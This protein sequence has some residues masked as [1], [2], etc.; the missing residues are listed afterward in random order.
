MVEHTYR[1]DAVF[2]SLADP[3]RRDIL[4]R[5]R[6]KGSSVGAIARHY[7]L[8]FAGVAKHVDVLARAGLVRKSR[9]GKEQVVA[10][11]PGTLALASEY[12]ETYR[13]LW[14][15]R[16]DSLGAYLRAEL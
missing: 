7:D 3:T 9:N 12:L 6:T 11:V 4:R 5:I 1:L 2:K 15:R 14:E 10:I 13:E 16:L 8:S